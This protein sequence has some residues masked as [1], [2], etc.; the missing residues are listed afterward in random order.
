MIFATNI[1]KV[2]QILQPEVKMIRED[3]RK[4]R[5]RLCPEAPS[6]TIYVMFFM[7]IISFLQSPVLGSIGSNVG[8]GGSGSGGSSSSSANNN[9]ENSNSYGFFGSGFELL[10]DNS[11]SGSQSESSSTGNNNLPDH[12]QQQQ[13][14]ISNPG[15]TRTGHHHR[16]HHGNTLHTAPAGG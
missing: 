4:G 14:A 6:L 8:G 7:T 1:S 5:R 15:P 16:H 9:L 11:R 10:G 13:L 12:P 2:L 3:N